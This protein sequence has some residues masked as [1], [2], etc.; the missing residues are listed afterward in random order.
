M[1]SVYMP[2]SLPMQV[3]EIKTQIQIINLQLEKMDKL[4]KGMKCNS[5]VI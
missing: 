1:A 2:M 4:I 3:W 5:L